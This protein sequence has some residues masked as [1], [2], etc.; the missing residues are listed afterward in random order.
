[1][2]TCSKNSSIFS[3]I[4]TRTTG[5]FLPRKKIKKGQGNDSL[6][7]L[8]RFHRVKRFT[9]LAEASTKTAKRLLKNLRCFSRSLTVL[10]EVS[11]KSVKL[12]TRWNLPNA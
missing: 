10:V 3:R 8:G 9:V 5:L 11:T 2:R 12:L 6:S 1:M 7:T 4:I